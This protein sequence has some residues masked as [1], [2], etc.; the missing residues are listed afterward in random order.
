MVAPQTV[1][2]ANLRESN[3][4]ALN[5]QVGVRVLEFVMSNQ[6]CPRSCIMFE[7][8]FPL[9][10]ERLIFEQAARDDTQT[11]LRLALVCRYAQS[12]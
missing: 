8:T 3:F 2:K 1:M 10:I 12:W 11:A 7:F 9:D 4:G 6:P 5:R